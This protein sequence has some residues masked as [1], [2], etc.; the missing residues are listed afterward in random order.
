MF[1]AGIA[2]ASSPSPEVMGRYSGKP[3]AL[4]PR[5]IV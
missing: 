2:A 1:R 3:G 4:E 5:D